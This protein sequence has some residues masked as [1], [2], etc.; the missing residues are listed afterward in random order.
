MKKFLLLIMLLSCGSSFAIDLLEQFDKKLIVRPVEIQTAKKSDIRN[1]SNPRKNEFG[2]WDFYL[3][4]EIKVKVSVKLNNGDI[5][6]LNESYEFKME[7]IS[8]GHGVNKKSFDEKLVIDLNV[9]I[10]D[11]KEKYSAFEFSADIALVEGWLYESFAAQNN[12]YL[13]T[14]E[15]LQSLG[16]AN[17]LEFKIPSNELNEYFIFNAS[18]Q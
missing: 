1:Y 7:E 17:G 9:I 2:D 10:K 14:N 13:N 3:L 18:I 11:L 12:Y 16:S 15:E 5:Q 8:I 4:T 6:N